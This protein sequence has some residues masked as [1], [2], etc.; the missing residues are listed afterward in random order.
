MIQSNFP[1]ILFDLDNNTI[2]LNSISKSNSYFIRSYQIFKIEIIED[3]LTENKIYSVKENPTPTGNDDLFLITSSKIFNNENFA[4]S[5][6]L[7]SNVKIKITGFDNVERIYTI[8]YRPD[9]V[10]T[11]AQQHYNDLLTNNF[12][13]SYNELETAIISQ[14]KADI[15]KRLLLDFRN[16]LNKKGTKTGIVKFL[17]LIG[18]NPE[19]I[20]VYDE[21]LVNSINGNPT[22]Q[23]TLNPNKTKDTKTGYYHVIYDNWITDSENP[24]TIK[25]LPLRI[26]NI[27]DLT[28]FFIKLE[29][30]I[31]LANIYFTLPEQDISFFGLNNSSNVEKYLSIAGNSSILYN[32][33]FHY[34]RRK[35]HIDLINKTDSLN[36]TYLVKN[37]LQLN[38]I[39][40]SSEIK[41]LL[42]N[43]PPNNELFIVDSEIYDNNEI[44]NLN[45]K[46]VFGNLLHLFITSP[47]TYCEYEI[48]EI[49]N[50]LS[51]I[52]QEKFWLDSNTIEIIFVSRKIS[53]YKV[54]VYIY[55]IHNNR[56][57]YEYFYSINNDIARVDFE[58]FNSVDISENNNNINSDIDST[59]ET[60]TENLNYVLPIDSVPLE[61]SEYY[62]QNLSS[63]LL[64]YLEDNKRF[65]IDEINKNFIVDKSTESIAIDYLDNWLE[66]FS[67]QYNDSVDLKLRVKN[68]LTL[69][70]EYLDYNDINA[71]I[72]KPDKLF[73]TIMDIV[74]DENITL[75]YIFITTTEPGIDIIPELFDLVFVSKNNPE[76]IV[77]IYN[78]MDVSRCKIPMNYDFPLFF[79]ESELLPNFVNYP[80]INP[81]D[82]LLV[83]S[84]FP[85]LVNINNSNFD[86]YYLKLGDIFCCRINNKL[87]TE[88]TDIL[89]T[90][91]N[92]FTN[93]IIFQTKDYMLKYR[94]KENI[95]FDIIL[96][97]TIKNKE[98]R[99]SKNSI[100]STFI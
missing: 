6:F 51:K 97:F 67:V 75:P 76:D 91:K 25:N 63:V 26:I 46:S 64:K 37:N 80:V 92:S 45:V 12:L 48:E 83:K 19:S 59:W 47:N 28:E 65:L 22:E 44:D 7:T 74:I 35:I 14:N 98:Y 27:T 30:A 58:I 56:E 53:D 60:T 99:I 77:S 24:L 62:N 38:N 69:I 23:K 17:N 86:T 11:E 87:I 32:M 100:Q 9:N 82:L 66:I 43:T 78:F 50:P 84:I 8:E 2:P 16:I 5:I 41:Y 21:Y 72:S 94:I 15:I 61:L 36:L 95:I 93:E 1:V 73:I 52:T 54:T 71:Y 49:N 96:D 89:W 55:D 70:D 20:K 42:E 18:F 85:R 31:A 88:N 4:Y 33:D 10:L 3:V 39:T 68:D 40:L 90:I 81:N 57:K 29:R 13:P 79:R 34:F